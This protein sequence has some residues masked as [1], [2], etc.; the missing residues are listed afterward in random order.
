LTYHGKCGA[1]PQF[2]T[3]DLV[4]AHGCEGPL[5]L[6]THGN[7]VRT[8]A[9]KGAFS[10]AGVSQNGKRLALQIASDDHERFAI[11]YIETGEPIAEVTPDELAE[12]Q[13]WTAFSP[14]GS[15]F[16][17]GSPVK[18]ALYRLP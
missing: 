2:L 13:S 14:D 3:D 8:I 9:L 17:V 10:Y 18:L 1:E 16:V 5:I 4:F 6:D 12:G 15:L 11:Y 7:I